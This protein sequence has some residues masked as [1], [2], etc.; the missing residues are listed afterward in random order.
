MATGDI[1]ERTVFP[2][3]LAGA[4]RRLAGGGAQ[5]GFDFLPQAVHV[6]VQPV[7]LADRPVGE[8][9]R[10]GQ[11]QPAIFQAPQHHPPAFGAQVNGQV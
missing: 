6:P 5:A 2:T 4:P 11:L 1:G 7:R 9:V 8:A 3:R 10:L